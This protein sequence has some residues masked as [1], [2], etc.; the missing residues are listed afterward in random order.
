MRRFAAITAVIL[1]LSSC[2][3]TRVL[4]DG[5]YRLVGNKV[6]IEGKTELRTSDITPYIK[7]QSGSMFLFD[8]NPFITIYNWSDGSD[9]PLSKFFRK[10]GEP[11]IVFNSRLVQTSCD[12]I[13]N[14][15]DY[16]GYYGSRVVPEVVYNG[17]KVNVTYKVYPGKRRTIDEIHYEIPASASFARAFYSD[18]LNSYVKVGNYLSEKLLEDESSRGTSYFRQ[19]G[20]YTFN[21]GRYSFDADTASFPGRTTLTYRLDADTLR[22]R[23]GEVT[24]SHSESLPFREKVLTD[25]NT[26]M[27]G[28]LYSETAASNTYSRLSALRVFNSVAVNLNPTDSGFVNCNIVL[29]DSQQKGFRINLEASSNSS[30]LI[31]I[32]PQLSFYNK[33]V[34]HGGEWFTLNLSGNFQRKID[35]SSVHSTESGISSSLSFPK[36]I[37]F[38]SR[39]FTGPS[40]PRTELNA[41]FNS[42]ERPEFSR[43]VGSFTFGYSGVSG[44]RLSYQINPLRFNYVKLTHI[45]PTFTIVLDRNPFLK[46][47]YQDH[48]DVGV[49]AVLLYR[50]NTDIVPRTPYHYIRYSFDVS[51]LVLG[52]L[53][54]GNPFDVP[55]VQYARQEIQLGKTFRFGQDDTHSLA[56]RLLLGAGYAFGNSATLPMEQQFYSG[57]SSSL[58]GWQARSVGPGGESTEDTFLIPSQTGNTKFETNLEYRFPLTWK[59]E[60]ALFADLGNVWNYDQLDKDFYKTL[61]GDWGIGLR[62]NLDFIL[63]RLDAGFKT[64]DPSRPEGTRWVEPSKWLR[65]ASAI[66]FGI[67][68]PF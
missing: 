53:A 1:A 36:M 46:Y 41:S 21:S 49:G 33:N 40:V 8:W 18:T 32:S 19:R 67:G 24:I 65:G 7:Q 52:V 30:G 17:K 62:V 42:Q 23:F 10:L 22:Y 61:A 11:P 57:G 38:P 39:W 9:K 63:L 25:M 13:A 27:P 55:Y 54:G 43:Y 64:Y 60:G 26:I 48:V 51:G 59:L 58:R 29:S 12:N 50:T 5:Q 44:R 68:Y 45:D 28:M 16:L 35:D 15:L 56:M 4:Q 14:H 66:H 37:G 31:G 3:T 47:S 6:S 2:S 34:F 20:Y